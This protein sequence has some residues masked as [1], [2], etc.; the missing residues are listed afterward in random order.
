MFKNKNRLY[1]IRLVLAVCVGVL[2]VAAF[3]GLFYPVK[4]FDLQLGALIQRL[5]VDFSIIA[6]VL[7]LAVLASALFFGR[8]YCST[9]CPLGLL[10]ELAGAFKKKT[11]GRQKSYWFKYIIAAIVFGTLAGGT[12]YLLRL[13]DPYTYF[14]SAATFSLVGLV[15]VAVILVLVLFKDR[16]FCTNICPVGTVLGVVSKCSLNKIYIQK[17]ACILCGKCEAVCPSGCVNYKAKEIEN[18]ICVKCLKCMPVCP[19]SAVKYGRN[20]QKEEVKVDHKKRKM[21]LAAS[22]VAVFAA[23]AKAGNIAKKFLEEKYS[24]VI[25]PPGAV[26]E[27]RFLNKCL[28]CNLCV[29]ACPE[30]IIK[31]AD[32]NYGAVSID[33][34]KNFC[35]Y[36]CNKC[37][38]VCP[39]GALKRMSLDEKQKLRIAMIE[40]PLEV[41]AGYE[42][43]VQACPTNALLLKD[44]NPAFIALK[45]IGC[46]ACVVKS[47]G[48]IKIFGA[49]IQR[50][51]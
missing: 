31:K 48:K 32:G 43:C 23:A 28:N 40:P 47:E 8:I 36:S 38:A 44:G 22:T 26:N 9:L 34:S 4:I 11:S 7:I 37:T 5:F 2:S 13:A 35:E 42:A 25:L 15:A 41:F 29:K 16:F 24:D 27:E 50:T 18:E 21:I 17:D 14:G 19:K 49:N 1:Q 6:A 30:K 51:L 10:Q 45:C 46:G 39:A 20:N 3:A 33:Y 12:A